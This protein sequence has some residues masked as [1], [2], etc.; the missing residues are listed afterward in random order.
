M[1]TLAITRRPIMLETQASG[2]ML[3]DILA[4]IASVRGRPSEWGVSDTTRA[5]LLAGGSLEADF[6]NSYFRHGF[7]ESSSPDFLPGW[8]F[9]RTGSGTAGTLG[10]TVETFATNVPRITD[11]GLL[12]EDE[13]TKLTLYSQT[14]GDSNWVATGSAS[15]SLNAAIA[16]DGTMT[17][18]VLT[19]PAGGAGFYRLDPVEVGQPYQ[20]SMFIRSDTPGQIGLVSAISATGSAALDI[21]REWQQF[22]FNRTAAG[23]S[24][25]PLIRRIDSG[26]LAEVQ[27]WGAGFEKGKTTSYV[28][29]TTAT[30]TRGADTAEFTFSHG[31]EV[32]MFVEARLSPDDGSQIQPILFWRGDANNGMGLYRQSG[33]IYARRRAGGIGGDFAVAAAGKGGVRTVRAVLVYDGTW[34]FAVDGVSIFS[35]L[36]GGLPQ[37]LATVRPGYSAEFLKR[38][39]GA[40]SRV[41]LIPHAL[42]AAERL[43]ITG[44]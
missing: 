32:T 38:L 37:G 13:A 12:M 10:N 4:R 28:P 1:T 44:A 40:V 27:V 11:R 29:T 23:A 42:T 30:A 21:T 3:T 43:A 17:A 5:E 39:G 33:S 8:T 35:G 19:L 18:S 25:G 41:L 16:P 6:A 22:S 34:H 14:I 15:A 24:D 26:Q 20:G 2:A 9:S 7:V 31:S 36:A